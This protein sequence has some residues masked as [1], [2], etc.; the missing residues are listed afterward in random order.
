MKQFFSA[1]DVSDIDRLLEEAFQ[2]KRQPW[3]A[4]QLGQGRTL[5]LIFFN[6]SL[7][8]RLS[9]QKA[10]WHLGLHTLI[11]NVTQDAWTIET[12]D[13]VCM[14]GA[15]GEH[16]K[17]AAGVFGQYCDLLGVRCFPTL[18]DREAD[19]SERILHQI[20]QYSQKPVMSLESATMHPLQS[21]ADLMTITEK[22]R[23]PRPKVV[24]T[25]A[26]Q[27]KALPQA[28]A[29]SFAQWMLRSDCDL[30][31]THPPGYELNPAFTQ[32]AT[33]EH[34][35]DKAFEG[36]DFIYAKNWSAYEPY[37]AILCEDRS[38]MISEEKMQKTRDGYF[39]H[40]LPVRRNLKVSDAVLDGP[41]SLVLDQ[42]LNRVFA[43]QVV[44][45]R[46]LE[47]QN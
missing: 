42:A 13:G 21:L 1:A 17:E 14:D 38:W 35:Q 18:K 12:R 46:M 28:V 26:P 41:R 29:N 3:S 43:A 19:Y 6:P 5:G 4:S 8:T 47:A 27:V 45:K 9:T 31:I 2:L 11:M 23:R 36:A 24:L 34:D 40:C 20:A 32:G 16:I 22:R 25:W 37:G 15:A 30:V 10:A 7:R 44:L 33:I 39:M